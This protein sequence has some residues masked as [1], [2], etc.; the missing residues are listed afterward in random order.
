MAAFAG[1]TGFGQAAQQPAPAFGAQAA[2]PFGASFGQPAQPAASPFGATTGSAP[3]FGTQSPTPAFG[4]AAPSAAPAFGATTG[5]TGFGT[6]AFGAAAKPTGFGGFGTTTT[7]A[8]NPFGAA[9]QT[10]GAF[11]AP[12]QSAPAF[13]AGLGTAP[14]FGAT[15]TPAPAFG[16][17][18]TP[19]FGAPQSAPAFGGFGAASAPAFGATAAAPANPFGATTTGFGATTAPAF[20]S[21]AST[22]GF[23]APAAGAAAPFGTTTTNLFGNPS[24]TSSPFGAT[25]T[26]PATGFG[27]FGSAVPANASTNGTRNLAY[28][29]TKD[30][31]AGAGQPPA[32]LVSISAL[33]NFQP[34]N[35]P[36]SHEEL[37]WEDYQEGVKNMSAGPAPAATGAFGATAAAPA[38][39]GGFGAAAQPAATGFGGTAPANPFGAPASTPA[40]GA[41]TAPT[42]GTGAASQPSLF[43]TTTAPAAASNPFGSTGTTGPAFG[44]FGAAPA[45]AS[46]PS[47]FSNTATTGFGTTAPFGSA[48]PFGTAP[49]AA[50]FSFSSSPATFGGASAPATSLFGPA[51]ASSPFGGGT[52]TLGAV[53][54]PFGTASS[55]AA[56][57]TSTLGAFGTT[58]AKPANPFGGAAASP[59][60]TTAPA[61]PGASLFGT[62]PFNFNSQPASSPSI[63]G[64]TATGTT[65]SF[66]PSLFGTQP[67]APAA[68]GSIFGAAGTA[69]SATAQPPTVAQPAYGNFGTLPA[70]P[71]VKVG[72]TTRVPRNSSISSGKASPLLSLRST[73]L[74]YGASV[75]VRTEQPSGLG[76]GLTSSGP[77][78]VSSD[79]LAPVPG[80]IGSSAAAA[81]AAAAAGGTGLL[82]LRQNPHRLFLA[83]PPPSTEA[84]GGA[85]FLTPARPPSSRRAATPDGAGTTCVLGDDMRHMDAAAAGTPDGNRSGAGA[86]GYSNGY[87]GAGSG[88]AAIAPAGP[89]GTQAAAGRGNANVFQDSSASEPYMPRLGRFVSEGY[90]F[91]PNV[92][93]L[94]LLHRQNPENLA[95]VSNF[96]VTREGV[97]KIRWVAPVDVRALMLDKIVS[98]TYGQVAVYDDH[99]KPPMGEGL[100]KP[101]EITLYGIY[102]KDKETGAYIKEGPRGQ[103]YEKKLRQVCASTGAK[104]LSY[105]LD[106]G[107]WKFEVEHFSRYGLIFD[108][109]DDV[110][111]E[112]QEGVGE[113][114][115]AARVSAEGQRVP[116][117]GRGQACS[118]DSEM[119]PS[120]GARWAQRQQG[121]GL[122][123]AGGSDATGTIGAGGV[124]T[125]GTAVD[126][127]RR[128][129]SRQ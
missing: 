63:F 125:R 99:V 48:S 44:G 101:A 75:R 21:G 42:F 36:K 52:N 35:L 86:N 117:V 20:G 115:A 31:D 70:M 7:A 89:S 72:I 49:S 80:G 120:L 109:D 41:T 94:R 123:H 124:A 121:A 51:P 38:A 32:F 37:R 106:G 10:P 105:K 27:S 34:P 39:F 59:F 64:N 1:N 81:A 104:F 11:G 9:S 82:P 68:G 110:D 100:N 30:T 97:G 22:T 8:P 91:S 73:P 60:G 88:A 65:M 28:T 29:K 25:T 6:G 33:L 55:A 112:M 12:A 103:A 62:T 3:L 56:F 128:V 76:S 23:G 16:A 4:Q 79:L 113:A 118:E 2:S 24:A 61:A 14:S 58:A 114:D 107:V 116:M 71:E 111:D 45:A 95:T 102:R 119:A 66:A 74:R 90:S 50:S 5:T 85:S 96:T 108:D 46:Q 40:F 17:S 98:I 13:G 18:S 93:E 122:P 84:A 77:L 19:A 26:Q 87:A 92:D 43:G 47:L 129:R 78:S 54:S 69:P 127:G 53:G 126:T 83:A 57:G 15:L 67:V